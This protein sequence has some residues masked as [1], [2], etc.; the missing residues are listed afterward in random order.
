M[1][2]VSNET[3]AKDLAEGLCVPADAVITYILKAFPDAVIM[4][5]MNGTDI[6]VE[7]GLTYGGK[8]GDLLY[9]KTNLSN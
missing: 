2:D 5:S 1:A 4:P 6:Y 8:T 9:G 3:D 7:L